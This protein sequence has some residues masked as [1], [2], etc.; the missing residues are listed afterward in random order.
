MVIS[1]KLDQFYT[2][3][4]LDKNGGEDNDY[5]MMK[6]RFFS[7]KLPN[8]EFRKKV[9]YIH[10]IEHVLF[11]C[12]VSW[13]GEAYIAGWEI[14]TGM[15]KHFPI[16][17]MSLWAM[18]FGLFTHPK[19]VLNGYK[20]GL[21]YTGLIDRKIP[22]NEIMNLT[23]EE[24]NHLLLKNETQSFNSL[25]F[26]LWSLVSIIIMTFPLLLMVILGFVFL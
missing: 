23:L 4:N 8:S 11:D 7:L 19:D 24:V 2:Q 12:D 15:W 21:N 1:Q 9:V 25:T 20:K 3:N 13:K 5:F 10:D 17:I 18:G 6:F 14:A 16:G 22:K 26:G